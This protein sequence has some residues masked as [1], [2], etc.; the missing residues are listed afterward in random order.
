MQFAVQAV[1]GLRTFLIYKYQPDKA[2]AFVR[3]CFSFPTRKLDL[4]IAEWD[5]FKPAWRIG[6]IPSRFLCYHAVATC[7]RTNHVHKRGGGITRTLYITCRWSSEPYLVTRRDMSAEFERGVE[8]LRKS[9][10]AHAS[11]L[12]RPS[13]TKF[14][15]LTTSGSNFRQFCSQ[16]NFQLRT[17]LLSMRL[18]T[19]FKKTRW[20]IMIKNIKSLWIIRW[21]KISKCLKWKPQLVK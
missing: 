19:K 9:S 17:L 1:S 14:T 13:W 8:S 7:S 12:S 15:I 18:Q 3:S 4:F 20:S 10:N 5:L 2:P 16:W 6:I 21:I 11:L